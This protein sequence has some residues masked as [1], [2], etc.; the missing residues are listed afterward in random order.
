MRNIEK[1]NV[2]TNTVVISIIEN[3][4]TIIREAFPSKPAFKEMGISG[5]ANALAAIQ[6]EPLSTAEEL[7]LRTWMNEV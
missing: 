4:V 1:S 5:I 7:Q 6:K 2:D 3:G